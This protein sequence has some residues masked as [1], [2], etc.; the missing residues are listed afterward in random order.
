MLSAFLPALRLLPTL[1]AAPLGPAR[2]HR[3]ARSTCSGRRGQDTAAGTRGRGRENPSSSA[4]MCSSCCDP[5][6]LHGRRLATLLRVASSGGDGAAPQG[7]RLRAR[8]R[9]HCLLEIQWPRCSG[10][11]T[12]G[13]G[14]PAGTRARTHR[15]FLRRKCP[16][17]S[18]VCSSHSMARHQ[19]SLHCAAAAVCG[20]L[21]RRAA[22]ETARQP[23]GRPP[24]RNCSLQR[25]AQFQRRLPWCPARR[26]PSDCAAPRPPTCRAPRSEQLPSHHSE[27][28]SFV[29]L[30]ARD[31]RFAEQ[32]WIDRR[33]PPL[34]PAVQAPA[35]ILRAHS[36]LR[37]FQLRWN[38]SLFLSFPDRTLPPPQPPPQPRSRSRRR[39]RRRRSHSRSRISSRGALRPQLCS[40]VESGQ[41]DK[42]ARCGVGR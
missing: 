4:R 22:A 18:Q 11:C 42:S 21:R 39:S 23:N 1:Q 33:P 17:S 26:A 36:G 40:T 3:H 35:Y 14:R 37:R 31:G 20:G 8:A 2:A 27:H 5:F 25:P 41:A 24:S 7:A 9:S 34:C 16:S 19:M 6:L 32:R 10:R 30:R 13:R 38:L 29:S 28:H 15:S 12:R